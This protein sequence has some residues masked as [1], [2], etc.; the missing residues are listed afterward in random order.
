MLIV[1][2]KGIARSRGEGL[3]GGSREHEAGQE[4]KPI[5]GILQSLFHWGLMLLG[6]F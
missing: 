6:T 2:W 4:D 5:K 1:M 3:E